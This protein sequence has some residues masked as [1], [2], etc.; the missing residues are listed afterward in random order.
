VKRKQDM[1]LPQI[2]IQ[3]PEWVSPFHAKA[4]ERYLAIEDRMRLVIDLSRLNVQHG[5]GGPF[6]A[7]VFDADGLLVSPGVNIVE[8][9]NCS[10]FHAEM[11]ALAFAQKMLGRY[12]IGNGG[13]LHY[14]LVSTTEPCAMCYGALHWSGIKRLV[15]GARDED[16]RAVGFDEGPKLADWVTPLKQ[17]GIDVIRDVLRDEAAA[18]LREYVAQGG[19]VYNPGELHPD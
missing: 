4:P 3:M 1:K 12:D 8:K 19:L 10:I 13:S 5:T 2:N 15:C 7:A 17:R 6:A 14:D 11:T 9:T 16:A 18:V